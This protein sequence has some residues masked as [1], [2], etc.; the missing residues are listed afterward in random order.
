LNYERLVQLEPGVIILLNARNGL[1]VAW[2]SWLA[3]LTWRTAAG[4]PPPNAASVR[5]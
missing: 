3:W 1:L 4:D 5:V 2:L